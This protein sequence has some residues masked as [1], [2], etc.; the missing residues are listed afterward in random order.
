MTSL[1]NWPPELSEECLE[2][3]TLLATTY[4]L[5]HGLLY[6]P[7]NDSP[8]PAPTSA[9]HAPMTLFPTPFPRRLFTQA[10]KLQRI[11]NVLYARIAMDE[12]F[13]DQVMGEVEGVGK[14]DEFIGQLWRGWKQVRKQGVVQPLHLGLFRSDYLV[15]EDSEAH[16]LSLKQVEFNTISASFGALSSPTAAMHRYLLA[17]TDYY[18]A[19]PILNTSNMPPN[20]SLSSLVEGLA[21]GHKAYGKKDA[22]ILFV[23]QDGERNV[24]DQRWLEYELLEQHS[25]H[26]VRL[27]LK[28]LATSSTVT[29]SRVLQ[30]TVPTHKYPI[31]ISV[32]Y[33]RAGYSPDEYPDA[34]YYATRTKLESSCSIQ[35]PSIAIQLVGGKKVQEVLSRP[36]VVENF[37]SDESRGPERFSAQDIEELRESWMGMWSLDLN[38]DEGIRKAR[39]NALNLVLKP[40]REGGGNN[41]YKESVPGFLD[42]LKATDREGWIAMELIQPP[43]VGNWLVR[44]GGGTSGRARGD[45][46]SELGIYGWALFGNGKEVRE[47]EAGWL[48]RTKGRESDE[49]GIAVGFSVLDSLVL[50][51]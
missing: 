30:V 19:S 17:A 47:K 26:V 3:L 39:T 35:C 32:V 31:E 6:L 44:A 25:I 33:Y 43:R 14:S 12:S 38:G 42:G 21:E 1:P 15:H 24:F 40:Q 46:V 5:S 37:L 50:T 49:G 7:I 8:P 18:N 48:L 36:G 16:P 45:V 10:K 11:Y 13:L 29:S 22:Y 28:A 20:N 23:T 4:A 27:S 41:V 9:I 2:S 34:S 51:D